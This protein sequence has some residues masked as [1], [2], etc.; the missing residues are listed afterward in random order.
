MKRKFIVNCL[1][2]FLISFGMFTSCMNDVDLSDISDE[3]KIDQSLVL[4]IGEATIT[5][6]EVIKQI[7][8]PE[9]IGFDNDKIFVHMNDSLEWSFRDITLL[10][11][12][13]PLEQTIYP[14]PS[15]I[16]PIPANTT[17]P[18]IER[19]ENIE[20]N[21]NTDISVQRVD[22]VIANSATLNVE[23]SK[24]NI[25]IDPSNVKISLVF[26]N[27]VFYFEDGTSTIEYTPSSFGVAADVP[28][29]SFTIFTINSA[30]AI[31][32]TVKLDVRTGNNPIIL[33]PT[34]SF[35]IK[36]KFSNIDFRVAFGYFTP[37]LSGVAQE[38]IVELGDFT[39]G[40]P[41]GML[42]LADPSITF[43][44]KNYLGIRMGLHIDEIKAYR[45]DE[46]AY[47]PIFATFKDN[48]TSTLKAIN[49]AGEF[50][51]FGPTEF[52]LDK[53]SGKLDMLFDKELLPNMLSYKFSVTNIGVNRTD[54]VFPG[55]KIKV[56]FD[57]K[58][59]LNLKADSYVELNDTIKDIDLSETLKEDYIE[60]ATLVLT[61]TNGLPIGA[62]FTMKLLDATGN[63]I[64]TT[65]EKN[66][67]I[68][69][70]NVDNN[71]LVIKSEL[72]EK[73]IRI[74][75]LKSQLAA[76]RNTKNIAFVVRVEGKQDKPINFE[77][78]NSFGVKLGVFVKADTTIKPGSNN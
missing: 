40:F 59:P 43:S 34:S 18:T 67:V 14:S 37:T 27:N 66:Y 76:L 39:E 60:R 1:V 22:R 44:I 3:L 54:W 35:T 15:G 61:I 78:T 10:G 73:I 63:E 19:N 26:P 8:Q 24:E 17:L 25:D 65:I 20:L 71:G 23:I 56:G 7:N 11:V 16:T 64:E 51:D 28:V 50:G 74:E 48:N 36:V 29:P 38:E 2:I 58:V 46:P 13:N 55:A 12:V 4:P 68:E 70:P 53:D 6:E 30:N 57:V 62:D 5:L 47:T 31:P 9:L 21:F 72:T 33:S 52:T 75:V 77:K 69:A 42:R 49:A 41:K 45:K 32:V